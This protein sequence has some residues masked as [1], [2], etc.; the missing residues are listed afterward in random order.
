MLVYGEEAATNARYRIWNGTNLSAEESALKT[1]LI[2]WTVVKAANKEDEFIAVVA[3]ASG[4]LLMMVYNGTCWSNGTDCNNAPLVLLRAAEATTINSKINTSLRAFD[5]AY[6]NVTG[7]NDQEA[8]IV[9]SNGSNYPLYRIWNSTNKSISNVK[10]INNTYTGGGR[11]GWIDLVEMTSNTGANEIAL[12]MRHEGGDDL[13]AIIW[14]ATNST[15]GCNKTINTALEAATY[16]FKD[17]GGAFIKGKNQLF[18]AASQVSTNIVT[19]NKTLDACNWKVSGATAS[20]EAAGLLDVASDEIGNS[21]CIVVANAGA[22]TGNDDEIFFGWSDGVMTSATD[23]AAFAT[24]GA[25]KQFATCGGFGNGSLVIYGD[26]T[27]TELDWTSWNPKSN[28]WYGTPGTSPADYT[29][30]VTTGNLWQKMI[31]QFPLE[32]GVSNKSFVFYSDANADLNVLLFDANKGL[33]MTT[34]SNIFGS[35]PIEASMSSKNTMPFDFAFRRFY[36]P[37]AAVPDTTKPRINASLDDSNPGIGQR[38]NMTA[39]VSDNAGLSFCQFIDNQSLSNGAKTFFN[40]TVAGTNDQCSQNYTIRLS[41]GNVINFTVIVNDTSNAVAGGN[42]N[43][44]EYVGGV[45]GQIITVG[46]QFHLTNCSNLTIPNTNYSLTKDAS[47]EGT[48]MYVLA[49]NVTLDCKGFDIN[50]SQSVKGY[51][52]NISN[53]NY[54][55]IRSCNIVQNVTGIGGVASSYGIYIFKNASF[56]TIYNNSI[57]TNSTYGYGILLFSDAKNNNVTNN[58]ITTSGSNGYG[59]YLYTSSNN[60]VYSN[61]ITTSGSGGY[62]AILWLSSNNSVYS[63]TITTN[64]STAH[65][66]PLTRTSYNN[67]IFNN[68]IRAY[69]YNSDG[70]FLDGNTTG[71]SIYGND[72]LTNGTYGYGLLIFAKSNYNNIFSNR[73]ETL[74][75]VTHAVRIDSNNSFNGI[76]NNSIFTSSNQSYGIKMGLNNFNNSF[77][78]NKIATNGTEG[79]GIVITENSHSNLVFN[80]NI[81]L[82]G[83]KSTGIRLEANV[84]NNYIFGNN[85][86]TNGTEGHG[87][88]LSTSVYF[89][90]VY[91]NIIATSNRGS[92]GI[93][94][95]DNSY[96]NTVFSNN[97]TTKNGT[98]S[99]GLYLLRNIN[100]NTFFFNTI[101]SLSAGININGSRNQT[102]SRFNTFT[103]DTIVPCTTGCAANYYDIVLTANATDITFLNVSFNK[104][105]IAFIPYAP[106]MPVEKNNLTV[107]WYLSVNVTN[108]TNNNPMQGAEVVIN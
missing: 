51:G 100:N 33:F 65:A 70:M 12:L 107:Q 98:G 40:K 88:V 15:W 105:R 36:A 85:I 25:P 23:T 52:V 97:I 69:G 67:T 43:Q 31:R 58:T 66:L 2:N 28:T 108:S 14:N 102:P 37:A 30:T 93:F 56:N 49:N 13:S 86:T 7:Q 21:T 71:N 106:A 63:N 87:I 95:Y 1:G 60:I 26:A 96:N 72:I 57:T 104:S 90:S 101:S 34:Y 16:E 3:N 29:L 20:T 27:A 10:V 94:L 61:T 24:P 9:Y 59:V 77:Y 39:N 81:T 99:Y 53:F 62:G 11:I 73:I 55:T 54:S 68:I 103:N 84:S 89:N 38:V 17:F 42:K 50:Y 83:E 32:E 79:H 4:A 8:I 48:C 78:D 82:K 64:G 44:S 19:A 5:V 41:A 18:V 46:P 47:S 6:E 35:A 74:G 76:Y 45:I 22:S 92:Y 91:N 80:N 75:N